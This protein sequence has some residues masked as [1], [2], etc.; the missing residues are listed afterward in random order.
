MDARSVQGWLDR[1]IDAWRADDAAAIEGLFSRDAEY[2][3]HP[4]D[5]P[6]HGPSE[7]ATS[8][9]A[10]PDEPGSWDAWYHPYAVDG[11]RAVATGVSTYLGDDGSVDRVYDNVFVMTFDDAGRCTEFTE[12]FMRRPDARADADA[13][14]APPAERPPETPA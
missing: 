9:L 14:V 11:S 3:Y 4:S 13:P 8:W 12:W 2:R 10:D 1:Y 7:I 6:L 5:E